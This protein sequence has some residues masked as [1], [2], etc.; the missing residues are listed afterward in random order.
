MPFPGVLEGLG[1]PIEGGIVVRAIR[2]ADRPSWSLLSG[3]F[4]FGYKNPEKTNEHKA[5]PVAGSHPSLAD[6]LPE[7]SLATKFQQFRKSEAL[8]GFAQTAR[9]GAAQDP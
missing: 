3:I 8:S 2:A 4:T 5:G 1:A 9:V 7:H 6:R